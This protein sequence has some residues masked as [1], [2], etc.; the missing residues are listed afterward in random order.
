MTDSTRI[1]LT[2]GGTAGHVNPALAIGRAL[3]G[4]GACLLYVGVRGRA[5]SKVVPRENLPI[6]FVRASGYPGLRPSASLAAFAA[7]LS[8]GLIQATAIL[9]SFRPHVIIGTGGY[10][11]APVMFAAA[12]LRRLGLSRARVYVHEQNAAPGKLNL[13]VGRLADRVF[14]TFAETRSS[15]PSNGLV[16]G[17]PL[18]KRIAP[19]DRATA[20]AALDFAIPAGRQVVFAFGGSQ[21]ARTINRAVVDALGDLLPYRDRLFIIHGTGLVKGRAYDAEADTRARL[22]ARYSVEDR[23]RI[24]TFYVARPFFYQIENVYAVADLVVARAGAGTLYEL[25]S[26]GLPAIII[27]KANLPGDHQVMNARALARCGGATVVYEE[28]TVSGDAIVEEVDGGR[29]AF[30]IVSLLADPD[31]LARMHERARNFV[32]QDALAIIVRTIE[33]DGRAD[34]QAGTHGTVGVPKGG[35]ATGDKGGA[36]LEADGAAHVVPCGDVGEAAPLPTNQALVTQLER[37]AGRLGAAFCPDQVVPSPD[38]RAYFVS[39]AASLL[40]SPSWEQRNLGVKLLGLLHARDKLPLL[41]ALLADKRPAPWPQRLL[42]GDYRQVGF[43]RRNVII[44]IGRLGV[45]K[46]E[47]ERA[48]LAAFEDPYF[49]VRAEAARTASRLAERLIDRGAVVDGLRRLVNDRWLEVGAAAAEA[50]GKIGGAD[51]AL[52]ALLALKDAKYWMVRA[53]ALE[54]ILSLVRR[55]EAGDHAALKADLQ[56]FVLTSTDF[57][58][59]FQIKRLYGRVID[60]MTNR[61]GGAR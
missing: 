16:T 11:S 56:E 48:L 5:E 34:L 37:A 4:D 58:P 12:L 39:R 52:P 2:G 10:A 21:G 20:S 35:G 6:R 25:A 8:V 36:G 13:V 24:E 27:P 40:A 44:A 19:V 46:P 31:R 26:L 45:V 3:S 14:L 29:L 59:E 23:S 43:I 1:L 49:E 42:G 60:A 61:E 32:A 33:G 7:N 15:F 53:A 50:L 51:D 9:L 47:V 41:V 28:T 38:D 30:Q 18:R 54:G 17:Y 55:G 22:E 57:K